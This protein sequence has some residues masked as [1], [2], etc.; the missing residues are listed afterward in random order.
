MGIS[1]LASTF[2]SASWMFTTASQFICSV[3]VLHYYGAGGLQHPTGRIAPPLFLA[4]IS[5]GFNS[6]FVEL[7]EKKE[8]LEKLHNGNL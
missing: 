1:F 6:Y 2:L 5:C 8:F 7:N 4:T 3:A